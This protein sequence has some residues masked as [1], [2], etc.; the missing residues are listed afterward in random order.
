MKVY[1][2]VVHMCFTAINTPV[3]DCSSFYW[4]EELSLKNCVKVLPNKAEE[5][6][7]NF[8]KQGL[9]IVKMQLNCVKPNSIPS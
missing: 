2:I 4:P 9:E 6:E 5:I 3:Y 7:K 1:Y 8:N